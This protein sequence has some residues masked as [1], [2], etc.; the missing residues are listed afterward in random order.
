MKRNHLLNAEPNWTFGQFY[1]HFLL[2]YINVNLS[3][4]QSLFSASLPTCRLYIANLNPLQLWVQLKRAIP[5]SW[6]FIFDWTVTIK[7]RFF[8]KKKRYKIHF[9]YSPFNYGHPIKTGRPRW[10]TT[11]CSLC[12]QLK[13]MQTCILLSVTSFVF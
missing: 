9:L 11:L 10:W 7:R 3:L 4:Y 13:R 5:S 6:R 12:P 2:K 1:F 8:L